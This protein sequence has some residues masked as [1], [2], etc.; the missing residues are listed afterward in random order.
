MIRKTKIVCT[1]GPSC[2]DEKT[3]AKMCLAGMN[4]A[5]LNFSHNT[6]ADHK[7][8][9][10]IIKKVRKNLGVPLAIMLDTKGPEYR[11]KTFK[12]DKIFLHEGD[13]FIFTCDNIEGDETAVSVN[14]KDLPKE[15]K[16]GDRI[17]L[18]NGLLSFLVESTDESRV[19]TT[20]ETGESFP[21]ARA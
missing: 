11:I 5:R 16:K 6:H 19:Y 4:V 2:P 15:M 20:V 17:L 9:I 14:Y 3:I 8:R 13:K 1:I 21:T 12:N 10:E 18:N 7:E